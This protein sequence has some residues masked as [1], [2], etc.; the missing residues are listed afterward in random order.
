[1][2]QDRALSILKTGANVFLT[3]EP[4][5]GKT[6]TVNTYVSY[7]REKG[8]E[9]AIT[10]STGIA[11]THI[12]G[13]TI[14]SWSGIGI[15]SRLTD[16]DLDKIASSEYVV[17]RVRRTK[18]LIIDEVS[19]LG[20][21]TLGMVDAV[22]REIKQNSEPFGGLQVVFV[23]DFFQLPPV[24]KQEM[25][26][27]GE[28]QTIF[29]DEPAPVFAYE[30]SAW[31][32]A[33]PITCYLTEQFRQDDANFLGILSAIRDNSFCD[34]HLDHLAK[35]KSVE[36]NISTEVPKL[37]SHNIDVDCLNDAT[38]EKIDNTSQSYL[39][40]SQGHEKLVEVLKRGCLSP[41]TLVLKKG[42]AV[43]F[44]KNN[45]KSGFV[46]GTLGSVVDFEQITKNPIISIRDGRRIEVEP[47]DWSFEENCKV[48]ATISQIP[49]RLAWA[50]TVHKSQ[51]M[52]LDEAAIDLSQVFEYGQGY[53]ALSRVRRLSGLHLLGWNEKAFKVHPQVSEADESFRLNSEEAEEAFS[54][55]SKGEL[56]KM[57]DNFIIA[58]G[59]KK[60]KNR[61][62]STGNYLRS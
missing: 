18:I 46:N 6:H 40:K 52:S 23:G 41:E 39:M 59:G 2:T 55:M 10:A 62:F 43:M 20:P 24:V 57:H 7:L 42:A 21:V 29:Y 14:H 3:G 26:E 35:R 53:V 58:Y 38:L 48:R 49:L 4:G 9:P 19:M 13:M 37:Y 8:I 44:T 51:G 54:K 33:Q 25:A 12:G 32:R 11:A 5:S 15:K 61:K 50:I 22:C 27:E 1:M 45:P 60:T 16:Y 17:K 28:Q 56:K 34:E 31:K 36:K 30:S 47:M